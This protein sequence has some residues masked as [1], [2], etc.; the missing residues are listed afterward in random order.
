[1]ATLTG[2]AASCSGAGYCGGVGGVAACVVGGAGLQQLA[3]AEV[4]QL[5]LA[6][7]CHQHVGRLQVAVRRQPAVGM[8]HGIGHLVEQ[9]QAGVERQP[10]LLAP[11]GD[12][13]AG[14]DVA[15]AGEAGAHAGGVQ[16]LQQVPMRQLQR[17]LAGIGAVGPLG[18]P[19]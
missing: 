6:V 17:H 9:C 19:L 13:Q 18:Q 8:G 7:G 2:P 12:R 5:D 11:G 10:V 3:N 4:Q 15:F 1:V 16:V 14:Q